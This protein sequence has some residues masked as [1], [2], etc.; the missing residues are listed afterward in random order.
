MDDPSM[1]DN[2]LPNEYKATVA[3]PA[4]IIETHALTKRFHHLTAVDELTL[5]VSE[6]QVFA[7]SAPT[8]RARAR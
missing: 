1:S 2:I 7:C 3:E 5:A 8:E 4:W 6:G